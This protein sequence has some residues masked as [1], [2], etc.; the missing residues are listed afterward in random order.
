MTLPGDVKDGIFFE[1]PVSENPSH[2]RNMIKSRA[3][4]Y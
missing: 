3:K 1:N 4:A 2:A